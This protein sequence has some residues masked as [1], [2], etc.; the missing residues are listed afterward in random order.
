MVPVRSF[1]LSSASS[2]AGMI[3]T[4][5][6]RVTAARLSTS[7][8]ITRH[9][10]RTN[11]N[12]QKLLL[13]ERQ[14]TL[15]QQPH[16]EY[17]RL[18]SSSSSAE[19]SSNDSRKKRVVFL[20]TPQVAAD[21]L[22]TIYEASLRTDSGFEIS[23]VVTQPAKR[24]KR[25]GAVEAS[26]VGKLAAED[27]HIPVVFSP[28]KASDPDFL[29]Q[30]VN[31]VQPDLCITA[32]YGQYLPQRFLKTPVFG[33]VNIHPSLLP[34]WRGASPVQRS[35]E[36]GD[37]PLG[38]S[39]LFTVREMDAGPLI[40]QETM[41][42]NENETATTVLPALF[43]IGTKLLLEK[44]PDILAGRLTMATAIAQDESQVVL[45]KLIDSSEAEFK[46]W[47]ESATTCH[48][49]LRGF[50]MWPQA[51]L[52]L[53]VGDSEPVKVKVLRTR[54][55]VTHKNNDNEEIRS[56]TRVVQLGPTKQSGLY[57]VCYDGSVLELVTVQPAT[58]KAFSARDFQN[59]Y[60]GETIRWVQG[61]PP[62]VAVVD[63]DETTT[64]SIA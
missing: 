64:D 59:G 62:L 22:Q 41:N 23:A 31:V 44:L 4:V 1:A 49:R 9:D 28:A 55:V 38:V 57:V 12:S 35:L 30:L 7:P 43:Q 6:R 33:T 3:V 17:C 10:W 14:K 20:G 34:R 16:L 54:V 42:V 5:T 8:L 63:S 60:P 24:R 13:T 25:Q 61:S 50:S 53:Q 45:A 21:T 47:Q 40:A 2:T 37:N 58:R 11:R 19:A 27:L 48:N 46:V 36:A 29:D 52:W 18:F 32:A 51:Y 56:S 15:H 26:P 39:V